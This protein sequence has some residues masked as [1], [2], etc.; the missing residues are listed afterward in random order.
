MEGIKEN[1]VR[2]RFTGYVLVALKRA[3]KDYIRRESEIVAHESLSDEP[4]FTPPLDIMNNIPFTW[5]SAG[6]IYYELVPDSLFWTTDDFDI[7]EIIH[8]NGAETSFTM[9]EGNIT[10]SA[11]YRAMT[12]GVILDKTE[13]T[14]EVEQIRS[15]SRWNPQIG[16]KDTNPQKLTATV[17]PDSERTADTRSGLKNGKFLLIGSGER[18]NEF[19]KLCFPVIRQAGQPTH[20]PVICSIPSSLQKNYNEKISPGKPFS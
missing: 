20:L 17:I 11:K 5:E 12:N 9:P 14:F 18:K 2:N 3:K 1:I 6:E 10:L 8:T 4:C 16:W 15:G 7:E 19:F 13:L